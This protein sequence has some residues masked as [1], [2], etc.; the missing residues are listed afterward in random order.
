MSKELE[1]KN[2]Q[3]KL[4]ESMKD[5]ETDK[6]SDDVEDKI[7]T[8]VLSEQKVYFWIR[9]Y[10]KEENLN[11]NTGDIITMKWTPSGEELDTIFTAYGK[12]GL[13][14]DGDGISESKE[15]DKKIL[16][17]MVDSEK[18]NKGDGIP[19]L[20]TLFRIGHHYEHHLIKREQL[21]FY[22]KENGVEIEYYDTDF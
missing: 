19:F 3:D 13:E 18:V 14:K 4:I 9:I 8:K 20:K 17:L 2:Y 22:N 5:I 7:E 11:I 12:R 15:D 6:L 21:V 16:C 10:I 1:L